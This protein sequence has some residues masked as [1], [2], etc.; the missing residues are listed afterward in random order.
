MHVSFGFQDVAVPI[1]CSDVFLM[2]SMQEPGGI[3]QIEAFAGGC[4]V[5]ARATG[6][7]RDTV[8]TI[9]NDDKDVS[10]NGFLF[11]DFHSWAFYDA[12]QR[13]SEF[14]HNSDDETIYKARCNAEESVYFWDKPAKQYINTIYD[15]IETLR[16]TNK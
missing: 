9:K 2:P 14:F 1:L 15:L 12:M 8:I 10:G 5:V 7:L 6:G 4:L 3:S 11:S 16:L 13:A